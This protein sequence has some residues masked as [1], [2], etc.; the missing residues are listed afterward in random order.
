MRYAGNEF[1]LALKKKI[2]FILRGVVFII[3][4]TTPAVIVSVVIFCCMGFFNPICVSYRFTDGTLNP[5]R[6]E[7]S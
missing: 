4:T 3:T 1:C 5:F 7:K 2:F 6:I